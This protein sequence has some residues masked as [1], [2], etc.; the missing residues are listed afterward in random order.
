[1][2]TLHDGSLSV[3]HSTPICATVFAGVQLGTRKNPVISVATE[4]A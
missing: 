4:M 1:M 2:T 3:N